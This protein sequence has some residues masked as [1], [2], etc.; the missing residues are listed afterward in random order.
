VTLPRYLPGDK[1][2]SPAVHDRTVVE[3]LGMVDTPFGPTR[4]YRTSFP[5]REHGDRISDI[6]E[7]ELDPVSPRGV[8]LALR[9]LVR[10][11]RT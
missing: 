1:V 10:R 8:R 5:T 7:W 6:P 3:D 4:Y 2:A 11:L 9:N